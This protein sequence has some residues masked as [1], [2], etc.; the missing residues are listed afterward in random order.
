MAIGSRRLVVLVVKVVT[1]NLFGLV[2]LQPVA[3]S[4]EQEPCRFDGLCLVLCVSVY[5]ICVY[6]V[7]RYIPLAS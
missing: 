5:V 1:P 6:L 3:A 7:Y 2:G 4:S